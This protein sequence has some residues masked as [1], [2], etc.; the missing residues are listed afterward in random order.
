MPRRSEAEPVHLLETL[1]LRQIAEA[2]RLLEHLRL[3]MTATAALGNLTANISN[4][5][6]QRWVVVLTV[7]S[8]LI[9][10]LAAFVAAAS[11]GW[12]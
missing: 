4:L 11:A 1:R 3:L 7:I 9:A 8:I 5:R 2:K 6:M 12:L 10:A